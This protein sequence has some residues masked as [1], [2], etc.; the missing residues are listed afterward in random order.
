MLIKLS[1]QIPAAVKNSFFTQEGN[2]EDIKG[3]EKAEDIKNHQIDVNADER[4]EGQ[5]L[6]NAIGDSENQKNENQSAAAEL[7]SNIESC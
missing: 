1:L 5:S 2:N 3:Q 4:L 6:Q 7:P